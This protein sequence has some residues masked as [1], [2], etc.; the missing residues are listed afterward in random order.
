MYLYFRN[1]NVTP[2]SMVVVLVSSYVKMNS[3]YPVFII[4]QAI[5]V[6]C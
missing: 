3:A 1:A 5:Y 6:T 2:N 4:N